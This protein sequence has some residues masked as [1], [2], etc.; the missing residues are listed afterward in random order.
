[1]N[2]EKNEVLEETSVDKKMTVTEFRTIA[3]YDVIERYWD[4][5]S[6]MTVEDALNHYADEQIVDESFPSLPDY[7]SERQRDEVFKYRDK[8]IDGMICIELAIRWN[9]GTF[10][11]EDFEKF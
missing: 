5:V 2:I 1:M 10:G 7:F 8:L 6:G 9:A 11:F 4:D 3:F